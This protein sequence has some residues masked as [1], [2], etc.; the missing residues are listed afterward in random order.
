MG[1]CTV[2]FMPGPHLF[3]RAGQSLVMLGD[4]DGEAPQE[5]ID[6]MVGSAAFRS[7]NLIAESIRSCLG[8]I[9][10]AAVLLVGDRSPILVI[11]GGFEA[12]VNAGALQLAVSPGGGEVEVVPLPET[13]TRVRIHSAAMSDV[14]PAAFGELPV[15]AS[16][17]TVDLLAP[18][19]DSPPPASSS[20]LA[21]V[22][23]DGPSPC[24]EA[25]ISPPSTEPNEVVLSPPENPIDLSETPT[26]REPLPLVDVAMP[27][28][29]RVGASTV[30]TEAPSVM[31]VLCPL[32][33]F[34]HEGQR[35]CLLCGRRMGPNNTLVIQPGPRPPLGLL[36]LDDGTSHAVGGDLIVGR[37]PDA[38][39]DVEN[40]RALPLLVDDEEVSLSR[41]HFAVR[42]VSWDITIVDLDSSNG[43]W[44]RPNGVDTWT[45][46]RD[47]VPV[48]VRHGDEVRA[49]SRYFEV[50]HHH[51]QG[52]QSER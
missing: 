47:Q 41:Q 37:E 23:P 51:V 6:S 24:E 40:G 33:H 25:D 2:R 49:G 32:D 19:M 20:A 28:L 17:V 46:L 3:L 45:R 10:G 27:D 42:L 35:N 16:E 34:N 50:F 9:E 12:E 14:A 1:S 38:H 30:D 11:G 48:V 31:G 29:E 18:A 43:T 7:A 13:A 44:H 4:R 21:G 52:E 39:D 15:R 36:L 5:T 8:D 26:H 22:G